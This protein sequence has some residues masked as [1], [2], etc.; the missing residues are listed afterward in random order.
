ME[1]SPKPE[2]ATPIEPKLV[3]RREHRKSTIKIGRTIAEAREHLETRSERAAARKK[4]K[5]KKALRVTLTI[6]GFLVLAGILVG[7]YFNFR[8]AKTELEIINSNQ[9]PSTPKIEIIDEAAASTGGRITARMTEY[10]NNLVFDLK[11]LGYTPIK[12]VIPSRSIREVD[13]YLEGQLGFIKTNIDRGAGVT[14]E[15]I[16]RMIR[17]LK[18]NGVQEYTYIDVRIDGKAY[19]K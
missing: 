4:D 17:Y 18:E 10:V 8:D 3:R 2:T 15:D 1:E 19:W 12:A 7:L 16:D 9:D 11:S 14:A 13:I 5:F 6:V